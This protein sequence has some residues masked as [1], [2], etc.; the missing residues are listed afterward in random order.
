MKKFPL[1]NI[2][3]IT[4]LGIVLFTSS[5]SNRKADM[6]RVA[7]LEDD[8]LDQIK[9]IVRDHPKVINKKAG[10]GQTIIHSLCINAGYLLRIP[11]MSY[12]LRKDN[13]MESRKEKRN[14]YMKYL[15]FLLERGA[16]PNIRDKW[17][18]TPLHYAAETAD[19]E[20]CKLL[21]DYNADKKI[22]NKDKHDPLFH[23]KL[24]W[25]TT[26]EIKYY[27]NLDKD[28]RKDLDRRRSSIKNILK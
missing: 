10:W 26:G 20:T 24:R 12:E 8:N 22:R 14:Y 27:E 5:C 3:I 7:C 18:R 13:Y 6:L 11:K 2:G 4:T 21:L 19:Y 25:E 9:K 17:G 28:N 16:N 1:I 23:A 15:I